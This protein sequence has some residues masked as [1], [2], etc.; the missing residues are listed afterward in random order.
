[1]PHHFSHFLEAFGETFVVEII[2]HL[3]GGFTS[4]RRLLVQCSGL[5]SLERRVCLGA[6]V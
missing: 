4:G 2:F 5:V 1:M 3:I 6:F